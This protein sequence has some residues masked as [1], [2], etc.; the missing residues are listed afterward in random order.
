MV[1]IH[2]GSITDVV[3]LR[4]TIDGLADALDANWVCKTR[5][6]DLDGETVVSVTTITSKSTDSD[7]KEWFQVVLTPVQ[8]ESI[9]VRGGTNYRDMKWVTQ[10]ENATLTPPYAKELH[11]DLRVYEPG[12]F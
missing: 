1:K 5:A 7:G 11:L 6:I 3:T 4:P 8:T 10:L 12:I 9:D 2:K